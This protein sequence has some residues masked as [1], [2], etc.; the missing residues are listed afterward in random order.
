[1]E[2]KAISLK[3]KCP[4]C[5]EGILLAVDI[6]PT[7]KLITCSFCEDYE[8]E[9]QDGGRLVTLKDFGFDIKIDAPKRVMRD[10]VEAWP[11]A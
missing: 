3:A 1:M 6:N 2:S 8:L 9:I 5:N 4:E 10:T 11:N 7:S